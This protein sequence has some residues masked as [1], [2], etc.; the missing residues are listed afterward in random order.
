[1]SRRALPASRSTSRSRS[2]SVLWLLLVVAAHTVPAQAALH[3]GAADRDKPP[4]LTALE[5]ELSGTTGRLD[6]PRRSTAAAGLSGA[7]L[8]RSAR[9]PGWTLRDGNCSHGPDPAPSGLDVTTPTTNE[10][11]RMRARAAELTAAGVACTGDGVTGPRVQALYVRAKDVP[12]R[13]AAVRDSLG[14]YAGAVDDV[15]V[16]SAAKTGGTRRVRWLT[17]AACSLDLRHVVV[18]AKGDD[19]LSAMVGE[20]KAQGY[21]RSD[22]KYLL[23]ADAT[24]YC[25]VA[26]T[27][28]DDRPTPDN[29]SNRGASYARIDTKC[30]GLSNSVEAHELTHMLGGVQLSAPNSNGSGHCTDDSD[31]MCYAESGALPVRTVCEAGHERLLD[32]G[33]DDYFSTR[34]A[35]GSY[36][37]THWNVADSAFLTS[38]PPGS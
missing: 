37:A 33:N 27:R 23:W 15:F 2:L 19:S 16:E 13:F 4:V 31:R 12:D 8:R 20:L 18:S 3:F 26:Q 22:R 34:P 1:M 11:L 29:A 24:R 30:W 7:D 32:C 21:G 6:A 10:Q 5:D 28:Y 25:G 9:C 35:S 17:T 38:L 14:S 36:L